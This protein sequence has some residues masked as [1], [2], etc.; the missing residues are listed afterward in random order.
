[1]CGIC[2]VV[3][4]ENG[5]ELTKQMSQSLV[6]RGP[7]SAG[8][9]CENKVSLGIRR[10][11]IIDLATGDQPIYNEDRTVAIVFNG[12]IYNFQ[13]LFNELVILG[14]QFITHS[15]T[16]VVVHA[17]EEWG[18]DCP[19]HLRGMFAFAIHDRRIQVEHPESKWRLFMA[20]DRLGVKPFYYYREDN[21]CFLFA[22]EVRALLASGKISKRLSMAGLY[23]YLLFG[24]LQEP[25]TLVDGVYSLPAASWLLIE[26]EGDSYTVHQDVYWEPPVGQYKPSSPNDVFLWL[27]DAVGSQLISDVPLGAFLSGGLDSG[28]I[29]A[30]GSQLLGHPMRTFTLAFDNWPSDERYAAALTAKHFNSEHHCHVIS[31]EDFLADLPQAISAMDLPTIDGINSWYVSREARQAGL[32]VALSGVGGDEV[33]A[34]YSSFRQSL[35]LARLPQNVRWLYKLPGWQNGLNRLLNNGDMS[36]KLAA[37][38]IGDTPMLHPYFAVRS[39]FT[40]QTIQQMFQ[41]GVNEQLQGE[42]KDLMIWRNSVSKQIAIGQK[43]DSVGEISWLELSQYMRSTL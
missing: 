6:H 30:L 38:I 2:G 32:T 31:E 8:F 12:E 34:G 14:H 21:G 25:L 22:S 19:K 5:Y 23:T 3:G 33:F 35:L 24:S 9:F 16:E 41:P 29:V 4:F 40:I 37:H 17:Y 26:N 1:M 18:L 42:S 43:F 11:R 15:D 28:S 36:R 10:L 13:E 27:S 39:L 7:D 20:R